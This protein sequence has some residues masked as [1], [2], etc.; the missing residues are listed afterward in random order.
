[1]T[2]EGT[3]VIGMRGKGSLDCGGGSGNKEEQK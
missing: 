3:V 1:M 2:T